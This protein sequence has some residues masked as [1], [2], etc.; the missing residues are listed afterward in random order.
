MER[1][2]RVKVLGKGSFG[3]ATLVTRAGNPAEKYVVKEVDISKMPKDERE[4]ALQEAKLLASMRH[5]NIVSCVESFVDKN[6]KKLCIV[7]V[8]VARF[9]NPGTLFTHTRLTLFFFI[10]R[11]G[12]PAGT[13][14]ST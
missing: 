5:P 8:R 13:R 9:P 6:T 2:R 10:I 14:T 3:T 12:A 11:S 1:Y 7:Q 4:A